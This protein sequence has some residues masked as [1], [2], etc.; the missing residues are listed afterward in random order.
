MQEAQQEMTSVKAVLLSFVMLSAIVMCGLG[1]YAADAAN[2][3]Q[4]VDGY[5][6]TAALR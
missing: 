3:H 6:V 1:I 2:N 4:A 5:G